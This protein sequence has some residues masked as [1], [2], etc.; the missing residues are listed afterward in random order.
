MTRMGHQRCFAHHIQGG[1]VAVK[2]LGGVA[3][4]EEE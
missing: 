4:D 2:A 3:G 1:E